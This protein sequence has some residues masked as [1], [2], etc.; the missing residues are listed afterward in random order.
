MRS[1]VA[2]S[3]DAI[4]LAPPEMSVQN[5]KEDHWKKLFR[6]EA[7]DSVSVKLKHPPERESGI[8][9]GKWVL[10]IADRQMCSQK[11]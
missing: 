7:D 2:Q 9:V 10:Q 1:V 11:C 4:D 8:M 3:C 5:W 6:V